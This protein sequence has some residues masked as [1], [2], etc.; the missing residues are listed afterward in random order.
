MRY[1][2]FVTTRTKWPYVVREKSLHYFPRIVCTS[3]LCG[4]AMWNAPRVTC[5]LSVANYTFLVAG[6]YYK[7]LSLS[8][9]VQKRN[10]VHIIDIKGNLYLVMMQFLSD[11]HTLSSEA[12]LDQ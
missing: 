11:R 10:L 5:V 7:L 12:C 1:V 3:D 9:I 2:T 8:I 6:V 4:P